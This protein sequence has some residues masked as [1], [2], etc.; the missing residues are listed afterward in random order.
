MT[1]MFGLSSMKIGTRQATTAWWIFDQSLRESPVAHLGG[2][3]QRSEHRIH[4]LLDLAHLQREQQHRVTVVN[5]ALRAIPRPKRLV[6]PMLAERRRR[7]SA[8]GCRPESN[9][10]RSCSRRNAGDGLASLVS[11]RAGQ[12]GGADRRSGRRCRSPGAA[13]PRTPSTRVVDA[14]VPSSGKLSP[15]PRSRLRSDHAPSSAWLFDDRRV[16]S[17][18][19]R[20]P[21]ARLPTHERRHP[22]IRRAPGAAQLVGH[23][24]GST[25]LAARVDEVIASNVRVCRL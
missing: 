20:S 21:G 8:L 24:Q 4:W 13:R 10:S 23:G 22:P 18:A 14:F 12:R 7:P 19:R 25:G 1:V 9:R 11:S 2:V 16:P 15:S 3:D 6:L 17:R 5:G